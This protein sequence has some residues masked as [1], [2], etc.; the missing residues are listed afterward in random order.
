[1][2][3]RE[4]ITYQLDVNVEGMINRFVD[5]TK[6]GGEY[7]FKQHRKLASNLKG[8]SEMLVYVRASIDY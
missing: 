1:M 3:S 6:I 4:W 8:T 2:G 7:G 5:G